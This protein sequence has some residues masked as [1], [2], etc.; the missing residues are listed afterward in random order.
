MLAGH[1]RIGTLHLRSL[2]RGILT[3][4]GLA[5][6]WFEGFD[7]HDS[8]GQSCQDEELDSDGS[9]GFHETLLLISLAQDY[10]ALG[11]R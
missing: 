10:H 1:F 7:S 3:A 8:H 5:D 9:F 2:G 6:R 4:P 11:S